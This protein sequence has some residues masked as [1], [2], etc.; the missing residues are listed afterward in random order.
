MASAQCADEVALPTGSAR[1]VRFE[2][3]RQLGETRLTAL[4][5]ARD[6]RRHQTV[7]EGSHANG[8]FWLDT[9][10]EY[11][12]RAGVP[13]DLPPKA[14]AVLRYLV[15]HPGR[16]V[17]QQELLDALWP[18]VHVQ[19]E[20]LKTYIRDLRR[21]LGDRPKAARFI[22]TRP[23]RGYTFVAAVTDESGSVPAA[24]SVNGTR[25][26][27]REGAGTPHPPEAGNGTP[28]GLRQ[29]HH[30]GVVRRSVRHPGYLVVSREGAGRWPRAAA[31]HDGDIPASVRRSGGKEAGERRRAGEP[32][33]LSTTSAEV[34]GVGRGSAS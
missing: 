17:T 30:G 5:G 6:S 31:L 3:A 10:N 1:G 13:I 4:I 34:R 27:A 21:I 16:L 25:D 22:E 19:P 26:G 8:T 20:I 18:D 12:W 14:F 7:P 32:D 29:G 2:A 9:V 24:A 28:G 11:L 15:E 23:R 33:A